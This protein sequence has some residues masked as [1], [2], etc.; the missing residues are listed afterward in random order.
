MFWGERQDGQARNDRRKQPCRNRNPQYGGPFHGGK[1]PLRIQKPYLFLAS[2][3]IGD[4]VSVKR[5]TSSPVLVLMSWCMLST[6]MPVI[7]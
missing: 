6:L 1:R 5:T 4:S 2:R 7:S 3:R